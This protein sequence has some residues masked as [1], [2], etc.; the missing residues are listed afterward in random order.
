L[1]YDTVMVGRRAMYGYLILVII[2]SYICATSFAQNF[3]SVSPYYLTFGLLGCVLLVTTLPCRT[4][5]AFQRTAA[6]AIPLLH[7]EDEEAPLTRKDEF[8]ISFG[9]LTLRQSLKR[10]EYWMLFLI[11][12]CGI[13]TGVT[14]VN[15]LADIVQSRE[16]V[17]EFGTYQSTRLPHH[18]EVAA[19]VALFSIFNAIGRLSFGY[20]SDLLHARFITRAWILLAASL[21]MM[22]AQ[23][24]LA[25][26]DISMMYVVVVLVGLAEGAFFSNG[27][28]ICLEL[29]GITHFGANWSSLT[30]GS[31]AFSVFL[32]SYVA[33][34]LR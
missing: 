28:T 12:S 26:A 2:A 20:F 16:T 32:G 13:G 17:D 30:I 11:C 19:L 14:V 24:F 34:S 7:E 23:L 8:T 33:G 29:L 21:I 10:P 9:E 6:A 31:A 18:K 5:S 4:P 15:N 3:D 1:A 22:G 27:P 25:W